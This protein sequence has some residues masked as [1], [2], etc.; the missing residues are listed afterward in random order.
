[1]FITLFGPLVACSVTYYY[2]H[3]V[4]LSIF[5]FKLLIV[6]LFELC[7]TTT[8]TVTYAWLQG[9]RCLISSFRTCS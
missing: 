7:F 6:T 8:T 5:W 4:F 2:Y 3:H 9:I 1:M